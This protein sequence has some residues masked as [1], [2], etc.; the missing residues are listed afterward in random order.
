M[1]HTMR[2]VDK[3]RRTYQKCTL[4][5]DWTKTNSYIMTLARVLQDTENVVDCEK[6]IKVVTRT[7]RCGQNRNSRMNG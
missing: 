3:R 4:N 1:V 2:M 6:C 7:K 5:L